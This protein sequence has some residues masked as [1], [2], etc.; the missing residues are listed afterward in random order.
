MGFLR[1]GLNLGRLV[2]FVGNSGEI[3]LGYFGRGVVERYLDEWVQ[4]GIY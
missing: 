3:E 2:L 4:I 1:L